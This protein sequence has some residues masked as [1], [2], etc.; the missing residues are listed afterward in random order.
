MTTLYRWRKQYFNLVGEKETKFKKDIF[1]LDNYIAPRVLKCIKYVHVFI[2]K[3]YLSPPATT[4]DFLIT[5][6]T[7]V[8]LPYKVSNN[9]GECKSKYAVIMWLN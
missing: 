2:T 3:I 8:K 1:L 9:A 6:R 4:P 7:S 5:M